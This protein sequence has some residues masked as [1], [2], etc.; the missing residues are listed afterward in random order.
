MDIRIITNDI[1]L[2][3][4]CKNKIKITPEDIQKFEKDKQ[5][6][7]FDGAVFIST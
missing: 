6:Q 5:Q 2:G 1:T 7:N 4:E 3:I